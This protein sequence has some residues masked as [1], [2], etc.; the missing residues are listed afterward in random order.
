MTNIIQL[1]DN[2]ISTVTRDGDWVYKRQ[3]KYLT[4]NEYYALYILEHTDY[5]PRYV[6]RTAIDTIKMEYVKNTPVTDP[7][8]FM[9]HYDQI[10]KMLKRH[11]LRHDDLTKYA[12]LVSNN[13][14]I[15]IDWATHDRPNVLKGMNTGYV[16]Q[17]KS[18]ARN[19]PATSP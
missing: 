1:S 5:V 18:Y 10:I 6:V 3:P 8:E 16:K 13:Q 17:W 12:V 15:I 19:N 2:G 14:P 7:T 11:N 9:A 4:D